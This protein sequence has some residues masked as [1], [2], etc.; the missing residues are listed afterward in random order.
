MR[1]LL[2]FIFFVC[3]FNV[4]AKIVLIDPGHGGIEKG[5]IGAEFLNNGIKEH[6][7]EKEICFKMA[8]E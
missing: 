5:A 8:L 7:L 2:F 4:R 1:S 3:C 6:L